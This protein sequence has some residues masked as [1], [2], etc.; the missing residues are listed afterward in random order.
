MAFKL[1]I[2]SWVC[3]RRDGIKVICIPG[4]SHNKW[5]T[6]EDR[7]NKVHNKVNK[8]KANK[9]CK[10]YIVPWMKIEKTSNDNQLFT[11]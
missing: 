8:R 3:A 11:L 9:Q 4:L 10:Y 7:Q 2:Y 1:N 6:M 5:D